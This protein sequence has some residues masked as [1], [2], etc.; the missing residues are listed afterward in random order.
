[1]CFNLLLGDA[2]FKSRLDSNLFSFIPCLAQNIVLAFYLLL[3]R[4]SFTELISDFY[5]T[6]ISFVLIFVTVTEFL[7]LRY[8]YKKFREAQTV[9]N[10]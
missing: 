4:S 7:I 1:M 5:G 10:I 8:P 6:W 2:N 9:A 3:N